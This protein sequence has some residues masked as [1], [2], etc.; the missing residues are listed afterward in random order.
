MSPRRGLDTDA[1]IAAAAEI[2]DSEGVEEVT[3]AKVAAKLGVRS[4]SLYN[5][6][7]GLP[8]LKRKLALHGL[9]LLKERMNGSIETFTGEAALRAFAQNYMFFARQHPGL[10]E[11]TLKAPSGDD[12]EQ[13]ELGNELVRIMLLPL[14]T[15]G[16]TEEEAIHVL[17]GLR[18]LLHG[19]AS[20]EREGGFGIPLTVDDSIHYMMNLMISGMRRGNE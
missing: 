10:Y 11:L 12:R 3:L 15:F 1:V 7:N 2:A 13:Q 4:P 14:R 17:R 5:H 9:R 6:V 18:S 8:E 20:I 16:I 19:F